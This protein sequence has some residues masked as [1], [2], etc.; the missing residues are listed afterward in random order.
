MTIER[1]Q[2][3]RDGNYRFFLLRQELVSEGPMKA[4]ARRTLQALHSGDAEE[5]EE[6]LS[7]VADLRSPTEAVEEFE[8]AT[9]RIHARKDDRD[10]AQRQ[11]DLQRDRLRKLRDQGDIYHDVPEA[12]EEELD[13]ARN[14]ISEARDELRE[15]ER[16][17]QDAIAEAKQVRARIR[18][19]FVPVQVPRG[20]I[21]LVVPF[22]D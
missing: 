2:H 17:F 14:R 6:A 15:A 22:E 5:V 4:L 11:L 16:A 12:T 3:A 7:L 10:A 20:G 21:D 1:G 19:E 9:A 8:A 18:Q 13:E